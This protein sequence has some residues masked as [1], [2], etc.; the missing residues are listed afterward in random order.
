MFLGQRKRFGDGIRIH[1]ITSHLK[2]QVNSGEGFRAYPNNPEARNAI[3][4]QA[5]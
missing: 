4:A 3:K 2:N 5:K 1:I